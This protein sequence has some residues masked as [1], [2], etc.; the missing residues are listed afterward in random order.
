MTSE[1]LLTQG[2]NEIG[3]SCTPSQTAAFIT[4]LTELRKWNRAYNLTG[5][6]TD[7]DIVIRNF[8]DS[9]LYCRV[10][11]ESAGSLADVGSGAGF[12]GIPIKIMRPE[13]RVVLI[14]PTQKKALFLRHICHKLG[15]SG[16]EVIDKRVEEITALGVDVVITRALFS[17]SELIQKTGHMLNRNG[18]LI[19][20]KGPK[21]DE[22]LKALHNIEYTLHDIKLPVENTFRHLI[23]VSKH[24]A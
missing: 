11:P 20:S 24:R 22:E 9:L 17:I 8:L 13:L 16:I 15:L 18:L 12:P 2:I 7:R 14:E 4:Y 23:V 5:L 21:I 1:E 6:K 19:L 3:L 10:L